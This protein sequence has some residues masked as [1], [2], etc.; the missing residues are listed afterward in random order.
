MG[1]VTSSKFNVLQVNLPTLFC[2]CFG[3][4]SA[5]WY[6]TFYQMLF[7]TKISLFH[8][9]LG[10]INILNLWFITNLMSWRSYRYTFCMKIVS[11]SL[12]H[13]PLKISN[14]WLCYVARESIWHG[15]GCHCVINDMCMNNIYQDMMCQ[16]IGCKWPNT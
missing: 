9:N 4:I 12:L 1:Y 14:I 13:V 15:N 2:M 5:R 6:L 16:M 8:C 10:A 7:K 3:H 11:S